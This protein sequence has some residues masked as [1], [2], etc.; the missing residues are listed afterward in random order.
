M[1]LPA[2]TKA[3][4]KIQGHQ[5][6]QVNLKALMPMLAPNAHI[7]PVWM[8]W[9]IWM[10]MNGFKFEARRKRFWSEYW[11]KIYWDGGEET[12]KNKCRL[13][14]TSLSSA[15]FTG[16]VL[17]DPMD[18]STPGLPIH[19]KLPEFTQTHAHW[20]SDAIQPSHPLLTPSLLPSILPSIR[21]HSNES[22]V[23]IRWPKYWSFSFN[24]VLPMNI[25]DRFPLGWIPWISVQSKGLS[26][27]FQHHSSRASILRY[28]AFFISNSHNHIWLLEKP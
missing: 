16:S 8:V 13:K 14:G 25:Q 2:H 22:A 18:C 19:H 4:S 28:S 27:V 17:S 20:V 23:C 12:E 5:W 11:T 15:Q 10:M 7:Q 26:R 24:I 9:D 21:V 6:S 1:W 3:S